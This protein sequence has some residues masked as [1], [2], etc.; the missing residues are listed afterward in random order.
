MS[1]IKKKDKRTPLEHEIDNL[2]ETLSTMDPT[3]EDYAKVAQQ[4]E[5]L[6]KAL[7]YEKQP[8]VKGDTIVGILGNLAIVG[9]VC[10]FEQSGH[11]LRTQATRFLYKGRG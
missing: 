7:T 3:S 10:L 4:V 6:R 9:A 1:F 5:T 2:V 11:I 8:F